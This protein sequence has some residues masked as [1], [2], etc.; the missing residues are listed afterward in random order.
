MLN[1]ISGHFYLVLN[2]TVMSFEQNLLLTHTH[3]HTG[4]SR[5]HHAHISSQLCPMAVRSYTHTSASQWPAVKNKRLLQAL[6]HAEKSPRRSGKHVNDLGLKYRVAQRNLTTRGSYSPSELEGIS[7]S[8]PP[9]YTLA[10]HQLRGSGLK[11]ENPR[12]ATEAVK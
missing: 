3:T 5:W 9:A 7:T 10:Q 11:G 12:S 6:Q 8:T 2:V 4:S 1:I